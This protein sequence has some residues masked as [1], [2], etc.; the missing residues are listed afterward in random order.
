MQ[1]EVVR[2]E[3]RT[4]LIFLDIPAAN[5]GSN[6]DCVLLYG[7]LD[8]QPEMTGWDEGKGPWLP[9]LEG[10]RLYG[11]RRRRRRLRDLRFADRDH[12]AAGA[13]RRRTRAAW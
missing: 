6:D 10:D 5:G 7:H 11:L 1:L 13:G 9:V 4:P 8:K 2:P 12:G 3:G